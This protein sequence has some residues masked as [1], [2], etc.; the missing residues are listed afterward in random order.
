MVPGDRIARRV[1]KR[2]ACCRL[3]PARTISEY[4]ALGLAAYRQ[5]IIGLPSD[6]I[7]VIDVIWLIGQK[8]GHLLLRGPEAGYHK[9]T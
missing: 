5:P 6:L 3:Y 9:V 1:L 2:L 8:P 7:D 4:G